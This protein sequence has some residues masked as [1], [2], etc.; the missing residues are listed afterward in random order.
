MN[1]RCDDPDCLCRGPVKPRTVTGRPDQP[2]TT[3]IELSSGD[4]GVI[5]KAINTLKTWRR[6]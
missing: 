5:R 3:A 1:A 6:R 4:D 2:V